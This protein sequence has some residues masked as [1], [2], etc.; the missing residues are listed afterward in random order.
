MAIKQRRIKQINHSTP[1]YYKSYDKVVQ[2]LDEYF[3]RLNEEHK[4]RI[5]QRKIRKLG[6]KK[7]AQRKNLSKSDIVKATHLNQL[8][9][10]DLKKI[11]DL[12]GIKN[13][14]GLSRED[15]I[16]ALLRRKKL[17]KKKTICDLSIILQTPK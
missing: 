14:S 7:I 10:D 11:A 12:R 8:S 17:C 15:L 6:L 3:Y 5:R 2:E 4:L 9:H 1:N 13:L 16:Y